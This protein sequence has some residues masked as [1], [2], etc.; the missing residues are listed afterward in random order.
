M[1]KDRGR[2]QRCQE[3][4]GKEELEKQ[5]MRKR[6]MMGGKVNK[7][8]ER[9]DGGRERQRVGKAIRQCSNK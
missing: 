2:K 8:R 6:R 7:R 4:K 1:Y 9:K 3:E 5:Q